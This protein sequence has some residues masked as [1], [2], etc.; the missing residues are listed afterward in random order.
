[1]SLDKNKNWQKY[2]KQ[3]SKETYSYKENQPKNKPS[4]VLNS[5][6]I[7]NYSNYTYPYA[8]YQPEQHRNQPSKSED[9]KWPGVI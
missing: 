3:P 4:I 7:E 1:M 9:K 5:G 8:L 2:F 6:N